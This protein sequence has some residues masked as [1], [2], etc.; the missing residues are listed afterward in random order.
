MF[1]VIICP[2]A[3]CS[4]HRRHRRRHVVGAFARRY[5]ILYYYKYTRIYILCFFLFFL[6]S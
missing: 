5:T 4:H 2:S 3:H 1:P 6:E